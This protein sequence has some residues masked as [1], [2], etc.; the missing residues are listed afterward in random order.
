[1]KSFSADHL[2]MPVFICAYLRHNAA[3]SLHFTRPDA[4]KIRRQALTPSSWH[5]LCSLLQ[6]SHHVQ[7]ALPQ[8]H[9]LHSTLKTCHHNA[10][11][12][13]HQAISPPPAPPFKKQ[14]EDDIVEPLFALDRA[15]GDDRYACQRIGAHPIM[16]GTKHKMH[17]LLVT[18]LRRACGGGSQLEDQ[19]E[20]QQR[21]PACS[22]QAWQSPNDTRWVAQWPASFVTVKKPEGSPSAIV[23]SLVTAVW[24]SVLVAAH[25]AD[26]NSL[27]VLTGLL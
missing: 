10:T 5:S 2:Q 27:T 26:S 15:R 20:S 4:L 9:D 24:L 14:K 7:Q 17:L 16:P 6:L 21:K 3:L 25:N 11:C 12:A 23:V 22:A 1:M 18:A 19:V 8:R 13:D